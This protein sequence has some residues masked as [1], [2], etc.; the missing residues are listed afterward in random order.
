[1][2]ENERNASC[3][4]ANIVISKQMHDKGNGEIVLNR[5]DHNAKMHTIQCSGGFKKL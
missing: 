1:M 2:R 5:G 4:D 3:N